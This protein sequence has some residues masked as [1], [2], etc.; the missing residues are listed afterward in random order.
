MIPCS[1]RRVGASV[2]GQMFLPRGLP[3]RK[4]PWTETPRQRPLDRESPGQRPP[5]QRPPGDPLERPL[6]RDLLGQR[7]T[8]QRPPWTETPWTETPWR[9]TPLDRDLL[10][11]RSPLYGKERA[12]RILL[13]CILVF[14][15]SMKLTSSCLVRDT[16]CNILHII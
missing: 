7:P 10:G 5:G 1:F 9:E 11:Q 2:S 14:Y 8:E 16:K 12:V 3:D 13:E 6:D 4:T 15:P